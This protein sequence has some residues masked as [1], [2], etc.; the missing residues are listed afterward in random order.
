MIATLGAVTAMVPGTAFG[1]NAP[2]GEERII[3]KITDLNGPR[4]IAVGPGRRLIYTQADGSLTQ[5]I[6]KGEGAGTTV[7]GTVDAGG[8]APALSQPNNRKAHILTGQGEPGTAANTLYEW[9]RSTGDIVPVADIAAYQADDPDPDDQEENPTESNP[10]GVASLDDGTVLVADAAGNDLLRVWPDGDIVTVA[11]LKPRVVLVPEELE[12]IEGMPPPGTPINAEAVATSVTVGA[13]GAY[14]VGELR[15][16]PATP[17]TSEVWRIEAGSEDAV[18][19]P[20]NPDEGDCTL[21]ADGVTSI[22][23]LG[24]APTGEIYVVELV[25]QS[26]LQFELGIAAPTGSLYSI[27]PGGGEPDEIAPSRL[28]L[29]GGVSVSKRGKIF[30]A[31]PVFED[32]A[33]YRV[34]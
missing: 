13:D 7:L 1:A 6:L 17:G 18:C 28:T 11:R 10:F 33:I 3:A 30:V 23:G 20:E 15:G 34:R 14:Y 19:D 12:G 16:F 9:S 31:G 21:Y 2:E 29:P 26:W 8:F 32:G 25:K 22:V 5:T 4:G 27:P 24:A